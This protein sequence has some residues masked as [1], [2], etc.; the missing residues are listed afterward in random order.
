MFAGLIPQ[1]KDDRFGVGVIHTRFSDSVRAFDRDQNLF[2]L[3]GAVRDS[4]TN[5]ELSY[6]AQ[7]IP[8]WIIQPLVTRVWHP[9]GDPSRN[10]VVMGVRSRWQ[11]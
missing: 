5:L 11:Y 7:I 1:R 9:N 10:A 3:P 4:E 8:G 2:G 6:V